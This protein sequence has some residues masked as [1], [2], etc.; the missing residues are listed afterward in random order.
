VYIFDPGIMLQLLT[1]KDFMLNQNGIVQTP[2]ACADV[3]SY[4]KS[5]S[6]EVAWSW[7]AS[8][9]AIA[10]QCANDEASAAKEV[11]KSAPARLYAVK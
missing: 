7:L 1:N 4:F 10:E 3:V 5:M 11:A 2:Q 6:Q 9:K 8:T